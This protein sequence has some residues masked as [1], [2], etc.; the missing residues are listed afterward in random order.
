MSMDASKPGFPSPQRG[1]GRVRGAARQGRPASAGTSGISFC[2]NK[3]LSSSINRLQFSLK[4]L[5]LTIQTSP[6]MR[7][8]AS[9]GT[10][11]MTG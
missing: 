7:V 10:R 11:I 2:E 9:T 8:L 4:N 3:K 6:I 1:E 5:I